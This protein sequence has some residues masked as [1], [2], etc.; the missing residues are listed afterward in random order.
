MPLGVMVGAV[1]EEVGE[2]LEVGREGALVVS[3]IDLVLEV[4]LAA[5]AELEAALQF[6]SSVMRAKTINVSSTHLED[7]VGATWMCIQCVGDCA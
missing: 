3:A 5:G 6:T 4:S 7:L 2:G 1:L